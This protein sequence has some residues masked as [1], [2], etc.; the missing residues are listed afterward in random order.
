MWLPPRRLNFIASPP[1]EFA[2][3]E[4]QQ[5]EFQL[6]DGKALYK[7]LPANGKVMIMIMTM[8]MIMIMKMIMI[9]IM[10]N[11]NDNS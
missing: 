3:E 4:R 7:Q 8:I 5:V 2:Q 10:V 6:V 11:D 1:G 9:M